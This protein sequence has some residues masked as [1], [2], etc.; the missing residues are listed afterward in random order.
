MTF[1]PFCKTNNDNISVVHHQ[2][3]NVDCTDIHNRLYYSDTVLGTV[4]KPSRSVGATLQMSS[5]FIVIPSRYMH[6]DVCIINSI[7]ISS[8]I[9]NTKQSNLFHWDQSKQSALQT[10]ILLIASFHCYHVASYFIPG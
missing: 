4:M 9:N 7:M 1:D 6:S 10:G 2:Q 8:S 5:E 3:D